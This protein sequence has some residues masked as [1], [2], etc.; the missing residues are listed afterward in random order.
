MNCPR[1][2]IFAS[3]GKGT[4]EGGSGFKCLMENKRAGILQ[5]DIV[6]VVSN[7]ERGG[8]FTKASAFNVPFEHS[9][10]SRTAADYRR[11]VEKYRADYVALSGWLGHVEGLDPR[12]TFNIHPGPLP[13]FGGPGMYG[14]HVHEAVMAGFRRGEFVHTEITMHFVT[15]KYDDGPIFFRKRVPIHDSDTVEKLARRVNAAEHL[16]QARITNLVVHGKIK[17]DGVDPDSLR[18]PTNY[19][20]HLSF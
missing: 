20:E 5:A 8:V 19:F 18:L 17:W 7:H 9:P 4:D 14:H 15:G 10:K 13:Q 2:L 11:F 12:T 1:L 3:G 6:A 16:H